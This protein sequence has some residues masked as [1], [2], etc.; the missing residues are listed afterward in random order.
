MWRDLG[1]FLLISILVCVPV[2]CSLGLS[3]AEVLVMQW[4]GDYPHDSC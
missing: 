4:H 2:R 3:R 1:V